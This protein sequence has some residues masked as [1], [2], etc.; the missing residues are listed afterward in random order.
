M[1][2]QFDDF[3]ICIIACTITWHIDSGLLK[4]PFVEDHARN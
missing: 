2:H 3:I 4:M 1:E